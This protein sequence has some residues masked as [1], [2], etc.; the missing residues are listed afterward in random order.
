MDLGYP[1][2]CKRSVRRIMSAVGM[3]EETAYSMILMTAALMDLHPDDPQVV[4]LVLEDCGI[5]PKE[6]A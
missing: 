4:D 2:N 1:K 6:I 5:Y 3:S